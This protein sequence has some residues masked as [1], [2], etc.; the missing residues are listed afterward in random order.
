MLDQIEI[1]T[2][3]QASWEK[4]VGDDRA[5]FCQLCKLNVYNLEGMT[6]SEAENLIVQREGRICVRFYRRSDGTILTS[7]CPIRFRTLRR[8]AAMAIVAGLTLMAMV[9][10]ALSAKELDTSRIK[11]WN[12]ISTFLNWLNPPAVA[13]GI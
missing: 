10:G 5:R 12:P 9:V 6:R 4:M 2:P 3:C 7:D 11:Q 8:R 1:A 13:G